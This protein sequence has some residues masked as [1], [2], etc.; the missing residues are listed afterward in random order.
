MVSSGVIVLAACVA[1]ARNLAAVAEMRTPATPASDTRRLAHAVG[2]H[3]MEVRRVR[4]AD[5][6][7]GITLVARREGASAP[8]RRVVARSR[9]ATL[10][11]RRNR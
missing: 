11:A 4:V 2:R 3:A 9:G 7:V 10:E 6:R 1:A 5:V 8:F